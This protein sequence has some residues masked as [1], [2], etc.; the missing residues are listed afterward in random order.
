MLS[1][2]KGT[3]LVNSL[4]RKGLV[5]AHEINV[6]GRAWRRSPFSALSLPS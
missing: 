2:G 3:R 4:I 5:K 6:G 1:A